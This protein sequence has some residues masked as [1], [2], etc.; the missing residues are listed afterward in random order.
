MRFLF[1]AGLVLA[2]LA[3][4]VFGLR[5]AGPALVVDQ[6]Q[7]SDVIL[8]LAGD[9][10]D[11]RYWKG[12]EL[13]HAGYAPRVLV[14]ARADT[15]AFGRSPAQL[16]TEFIQRS[17]PDLAV[18]VCPTVGDSTLL[19]LQ[20]AQQCFAPAGAR[21]VLIV[22]SDYHTRRA[23]SIA[24]ARLPAYT[25]SAAAADNGLLST[26]RW[27]SK[28]AVVKEVFLEWQKFLWW[29]LVESHK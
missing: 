1:K 12:I 21:S 9:G 5:R 13:F 24:Q 14:N 6:P 23:L 25:W 29:R 16:E 10:N 19:E 22:T 27:W 4:V 11:V 17:A 3:L 26:P 18:R 28:R 2:L 7:R 15:I 8:V 20:S